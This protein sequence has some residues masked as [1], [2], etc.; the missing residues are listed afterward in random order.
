MLKE[1]MKWVIDTIKAE[2]AEAM[3]SIKPPAP[4]T[5][6][7]VEVDIDA[8]HKAGCVTVTGELGNKYTHGGWVEVTSE[9]VPVTK[10]SNVRAVTENGVIFAKEVQA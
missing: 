10:L 1:E 6:K 3:K 2:V 4:I 5:P 7:P 8:P 9:V